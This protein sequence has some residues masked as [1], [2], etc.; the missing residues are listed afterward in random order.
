MLGHYIALRQSLFPLL[1]AVFF[2]TLLHFSTVPL[3]VRVLRPSET[4]HTTYR[5]RQEESY[6]TLLTCELYAVSDIAI[7]LLL[8]L[9]A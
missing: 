9:T 3:N 1:K 8:A 5:R 2:F 4:G 7:D 6:S